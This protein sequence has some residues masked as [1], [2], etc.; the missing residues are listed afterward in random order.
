M[1]K[2]Y[3][4]KEQIGGLD[5]SYLRPSGKKGALALTSKLTYWAA[6]RSLPSST[7][8]HTPSAIHSETHDGE[9]LSNLTI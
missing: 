1:V 6:G 4:Q 2:A 9:F 3:S 8:S 5:I 7:A